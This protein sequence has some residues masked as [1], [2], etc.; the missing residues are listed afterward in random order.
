MDYA[1]DDVSTIKARMDAIQR[2]NKPMIDRI[3]ALHGFDLDAVG[4]N[5][6][7]PRQVQEN[8]WTYRSRIKAKIGM[9]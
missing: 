5:Q 7:V 6:C 4:A 9:I 8:D 3:E 1:A 2:E